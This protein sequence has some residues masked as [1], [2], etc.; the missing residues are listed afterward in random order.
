MSFFDRARARDVVDRGRERAEAQAVGAVHDGDD[1]TLVVEVDRDTEV[2]RLVHDERVAVDAGVDAADRRAA[3]RR[4]RARR[5]AGTSA[6][7]FAPPSARVRR[8]DRRVVGARRRT[9][10]CAEVCFDA[11][12]SPAARLRTLLNGTISSP[13]SDAGPPSATSSRVTRPSVPVPVT[14][15]G[16]T[17]RAAATR[18]TA[19]ERKSDTSRGP[20]IRHGG[21]DSV[22]VASGF[23][24]RAQG[25]PYPR[26]ARPKEVCACTCSSVPMST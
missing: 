11:S 25:R 26:R 3:R 19:G 21:T 8:F 12:S 9:K 23:A 15:A 10:V 13:R 22:P 4:R 6:R 14:A 5:T 1:E 18:R 2:D 16:S 7:T 17:P 24:I 20:R